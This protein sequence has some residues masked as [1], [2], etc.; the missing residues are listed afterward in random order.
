MAQ[1]NRVIRAQSGEHLLGSLPRRGGHSRRSTA[2]PWVP[3]IPR[4]TLSRAGL[5]QQSLDVNKRAGASHQLLVF[6]HCFRVAVG[7]AS[8]LGLLQAASP[9]AS[10]PPPL[11]LACRNQARGLLSPRLPAP[12]LQYLFSP[13][14][15]SSPWECCGSAPS[16]KGQGTTSSTGYNTGVPSSPRLR[17]PPRLKEYYRFCRCVGNQADQRPAA[18]TP[19]P[20]PPRFSCKPASDESRPG[21]LRR[22]QGVSHHCNRRSPLEILVICFSGI[23]LT[24]RTN[25]P[26]F[27]S[28]HARQAAVG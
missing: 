6:P 4:P 15:R 12:P 14:A 20:P 16:S 2:L 7:C 23:S 5:L 19:L 17:E 24:Q 3:P 18:F 11:S 13:I 28:T 27:K 21:P 8:F 9:S 25:I 26:A 1:Q 10:T 22:L